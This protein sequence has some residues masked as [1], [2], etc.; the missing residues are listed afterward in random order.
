MKIMPFNTK[1]MLNIRLLAT[2]AAIAVLLPWQSCSPPAPEP[3]F[4]GLPAERTGIHF[5]NELE[6]SEELNIITFE[7]FYN[8]AGVGAGDIDRDGLPDLCF[9]GN[10]AKTRL[11]RNLGNLQFED[12]TEQAGIDTR[13]RWATG[14]AM[15][16]INADGW[17]DLYISCAGPYG[18]ERRANLCYLNNQDGTFSE[19]AEALGIADT[20]HSTQAAFFDYDRDGD[21]DLYLL[22][23]ITEELGPNVIREKKAHGESPNTDR[24]YRNDGGTFTNVSA[25][26]GI[27]KEGYGLGVTVTDINQDGW[28]DLYVSNDYLSN[29]LLYINQQDGTF[30]DR[31]ADY[32]RHTSYSAMGNDVADFNND[33][34]PDIVT[35]DMLPPD[36]RRRK[37]MIGSINY[38]RFRSEMVTGYAPQYMRNTLQL[39]Q[40]YAPD[41]SLV[42]SEIGQLA[43]V[44]STDWSWSPLLAD[45]DNDG[46]KDLLIT[47]GYP[48]DITN[49]DFSSYKMNKLMQGRYDPSMRATFLQAL[50]QLDGAYLP[51]Y[52]FRNQ[53]GITFEDASEDWGFTQPSYSH[54]AALAD[55]DADGDL[56]YIVNNTHAPAQVYENTLAEANY[57]QITLKASDASPIGSKVWAYS[58]G[59]VQYQEL[60]P[61]RG[62]QSSVEPLLHFGLGDAQSVDSIRIAWPDG[63][64]QRI[65]ATPAGQRIEIQQE[66]ATASHLPA[67]AAGQPLLRNVTRELGIDYRHREPH[68]AD[69]K[70]QPLLPHKHSQQG[71]P[72]SVGDLNGDQLEDFFVGGAFRQAGQL[73][74]Q[75][76]D[77]TFRQQPLSIAG[78]QYEEQV[79]SLLFDADQ[80]GDLDLYLNNGGSEFKSGSPYYQDQLLLNDGN[81]VFELAADALPAMRVSSSCAAA[82]DYDGDGDLDLFVGGRIEP[83]NYALV[84]P[85]YLLENQGGRFV[86]VTDKTAP[87]L[88]HIGRVATALWA[89]VNEDG[90]PDLLLAGEWMPITL[91]LRSEDGFELQPLPHSNGWWNTLYRSDI[92]QDGDPD[93]IAG[94]LG[95]N[96]PYRPSAEHPLRL[97]I[98]DYDEN[99]QPD[100][101]MTYYLQDKEVPFHFRD[102]LLSRFY[103]LRKRFPDYTSYAQSGWADLFPAQSGQSVEIESFASVWIENDG[104][105]LTLHELPM[106]AQLGPIHGIAAAD[107]N[108]DGQA[109]LLLSGNSYA[110]ETHTGRYDALN[111]LVLLQDSSRFRPCAIAESGLYLPGDQKS[112]ILLKSVNNQ[113]LIIGGS[114][115]GKLRAFKFQDLE[116][117]SAHI[118]FEHR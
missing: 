63:S 101:V 97:R 91:A 87:K 34:R 67:P 57:L 3:L 104:G 1:H 96:N 16:D 48:K 79:G 24:L 40:G 41:S 43:G 19:R 85:S 98:A 95:Q 75:Q 62:F 29:D 93:F 71:P 4:R 88:R 2:A 74:F 38:D 84:P 17:L 110:T 107:V 47:N 50:Q 23:N 103:S 112:L 80:D 105:Q 113:R 32:F 73:F 99:E 92:D 46:W 30:L 37:L 76:T 53:G 55:L 5:S 54:G 49:L 21:L 33:A 70:V 20:G 90:Q 60:M 61:F 77:G 35:V 28:P 27:L 6:A 7:Y 117:I 44:H 111:G 52:A 18:P 69:F 102:D 9:T 108:R 81:G 64:V 56:D 12:M 89:D 114:N 45:I 116:S 10:M 39:N 26:A 65:G 51:N 68:Y 86:D 11:Y 82:A 13:G 115:N 59:R 15:A 22:T 42:F 58:G 25:Q 8:G 14:I 72:I 109:D 106:P 83:G 36:N 100:A 31:A 66:A 94:N 78:E 118:N